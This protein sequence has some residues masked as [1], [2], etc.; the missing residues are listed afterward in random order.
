[1]PQKQKKTKKKKLTMVKMLSSTKYNIYCY[2]SKTVSLLNDTKSKKRMQKKK[3]TT[4]KMLCVS[5]FI[6]TIE[7][8]IIYW[9]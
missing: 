3:V 6:I 2:C 7:K 5:T 4:I 1:M 8:L 9:M